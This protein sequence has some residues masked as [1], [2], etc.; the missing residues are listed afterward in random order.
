MK[1]LD[2]APD[3]TYKGTVGGVNFYQT[4][5]IWLHKEKH[6]M[7]DLPIEHRRR[8]ILTVAED[9]DTFTAN[10]KDEAGMDF[11]TTSFPREEFAY[12]W[13][14]YVSKMSSYEVSDAR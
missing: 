1:Q 4:N 7:F 2:F 14:L 11:S 9:G 8:F 3:L 5:F 13:A 10:I 12:K 6:P